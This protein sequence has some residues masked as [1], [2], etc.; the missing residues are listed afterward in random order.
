[1][2]EKFVSIYFLDWLQ[3]LNFKSQV[4]VRGQTYNVVLTVQIVVN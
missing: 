2:R 3:D 1:M 4:G